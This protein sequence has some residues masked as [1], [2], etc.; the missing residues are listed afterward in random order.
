MY[1]RKSINKYEKEKKEHEGFH[2]ATAQKLLEFLVLM[3]KELPWREF[4]KNDGHDLFPMFF[5][6]TLY[7][8]D[9]KYSVYNTSPVLDFNGKVEEHDNLLWKMGD[10][11]RTES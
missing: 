1:I 2:Q 7:G 9:I 3:D 10:I 5:K 11:R 6:M 8:E 4:Y